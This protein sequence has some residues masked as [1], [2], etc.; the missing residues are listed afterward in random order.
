MRD[1]IGRVFTDNYVSN[2][3]TFFAAAARRKSE[4]LGNSADVAC[5]GFGNVDYDEEL[6]LRRRA[7]RG[8][9][10]NARRMR[11]IRPARPTAPPALAARPNLH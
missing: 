3:D 6:L 7:R 1:T 4:R 10:R 5:I 11:S 2:V 9:L 8:R